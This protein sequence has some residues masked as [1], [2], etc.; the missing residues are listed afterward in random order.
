[1][2]CLKVNCVRFF[3][4]D[5]VVV[6]EAASPSSSGYLRNGPER[7]CIKVAKRIPCRSFETNTIRSV[8]LFSFI[9]FCCYSLVHCM[10]LVGFLI[11]HLRLPI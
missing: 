10:P 11:F 5:L 8:F 1:M 2:I 3:Q 4:G 6:S 7:H 9:V